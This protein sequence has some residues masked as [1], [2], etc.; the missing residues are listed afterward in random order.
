MKVLVTGSGGQLGREL[1]RLLPERGYDTIA[2]TRAELDITD[3][4]AV[5]RVIGEHESELLIN[6]AAYNA[7]DAAEKEIEEAYSVN[8]FGPHNLAIV[9]ERAGCGLMHLSTNYVFDGESERPYEPFDPPN[10]ISAYGRSKLAGEE[11]VRD[12]SS[13]WYVVRTA[14]VYGE[15]ANFVRTMLRAGAEKGA[16]RVKNDEYISPTYALDL[17]VGILELVEQESYGLYHL[18]NSGSCSWYE[19]ACEIFDLAGASVEVTPVPSSEYQLPAARP[20][21][22]VLSPLGGPKLRHWREALSSYLNRER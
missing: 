15:G 19:F 17:A 20:A 6:A 21:N 10:P 16:V 4:Q 2:L 11:Y 3:I 13:R 22:G 9:C 18:T 5:R 14:G 1:S 8:A 12:F 7:V